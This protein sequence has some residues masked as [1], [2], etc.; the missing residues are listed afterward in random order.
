MGLTIFL[1]SSSNLGKQ[2]E[3]G[4]LDSFETHSKRKQHLVENYQEILPLAKK[5]VNMDKM[6]LSHLRLTQINKI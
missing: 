4:C 3:R 6:S 2:N 5:I 1:E